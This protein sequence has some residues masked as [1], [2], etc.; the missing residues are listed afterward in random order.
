MRLLE[1][2]I[3]PSFSIPKEPTTGLDAFNSYIILEILWKLAKKGR[4]VILSVHAPRTD[5]YVLFDRILL[6]S[7]GQTVF[8]GSRSDCLPW[9]ESLGKPLRTHINPLD[10]LIDISTVDKRSQQVEEQT[11]REVQSLIE[12]WKLRFVEPSSSSPLYTP[13]SALRG[14]KQF[15]TAPATRPAEFSFDSQRP[16]FFSQLNVLLRR[17]HKSLY[18]NYTLLLAFLGQSVLLALLLGM[19]F[20]QLGP[21]PTDIQSLKNLG[22]VFMTT[23]WYLGEWNALALRGLT[24]DG[25]LETI[26]VQGKLYSLPPPSSGHLANS[27][28]TTFSMQSI[29]EHPLLNS[30]RTRLIDPFH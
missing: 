24:D 20:Y 9:F 16:G 6:L 30:L 27:K 21:S 29:G 2:T 14:G 22:F 26:V 18:R 15:P 12:A 13:S 5:A 10:F 8:S 7:N 1:S 11:S 4:T 25:M 23:Y 19:T 3:I 17:D 28:S